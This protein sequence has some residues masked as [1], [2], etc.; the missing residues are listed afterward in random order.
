M[1]AVTSSNPGPSKNGPSTLHKAIV[2]ARACIL[3]LFLALASCFSP[4]GRSQVAITTGTS[5]RDLVGTYREQATGKS[6]RI[7]EKGGQL[8]CQSADGLA[9]SEFRL[10]QVV[11]GDVFEIV[12]TNTRH[13]VS[14]FRD[15][16]GKVAGLKFGGNTFRLDASDGPEAASSSESSTGPLSSPAPFPGPHPARLPQ[17]LRGKIGDFADQ[18]EKDVFI[19]LERSRRLYLRDSAGTEHPLKLLRVSPEGGQTSSTYTSGEAEPAWVLGFKQHGS[20]PIWQIFT[21]IGPYHRL[22][23]SVPGGSSSVNLVKPIRSL[24]EIRNEALAA[25]PPEE[26]GP[27]RKSDLV[28]LAKLD[29]AIRFDIRYATANNFLG[30]PVYTQARAFLQQPAAEA[31][32]R[33]LQRLKPDGYGLLIHDGYRP[34]YVTKI[35]WEATPSDGKI[36]VAD[37]AQG[38]RHNRGCAVDL[39]LYDLRTDEPVEMTGLYDEMSPRSFPE[40]PGGTSLQRWH[41]D[42]LRWAMELEGFTV[43]DHEWWH[44]DYKDW[45]EYPI[46][47][48]PFEKLQFSE[49]QVP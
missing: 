13:E 48:V 34:W 23:Y 19:I 40:Y 31:L 47:N 33:A 42:L 38:S 14:F 7:L 2:Y 24:K 11:P 39:T 29:P 49:T 9:L 45:H 32:V 36:F 28:E 12:E 17:D 16:S 3:I 15:R 27:F 30:T 22:P 46:L 4:P 20:D 44:F 1:S 37:P 10:V 25:S 21:Q 43:Y 35:F 6:L 5:W 41:R 26:K 8:F 18:T